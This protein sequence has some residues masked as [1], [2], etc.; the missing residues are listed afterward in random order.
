MNKVIDIELLYYNFKSS[1]VGPYQWQC[2]NCCVCEVGPKVKHRDVRVLSANFLFFFLP[3]FTCFLLFSIHI[4]PFTL[5][6]CCFPAFFFYLG[7]FLFFFFFFFCLGPLSS[8]VK[9]KKSLIFTIF[10]SDGV[11]SMGACRTSNWGGG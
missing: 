1:A 8:L 9:Y 10:C 4:W 6:L 3:K 7:L 2:Q 11:V 5:I